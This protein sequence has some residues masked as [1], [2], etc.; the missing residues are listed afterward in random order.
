MTQEQ[1]DK[2]VQKLVKWGSDFEK[3]ARG[4]TNEIVKLNKE[5]RKLCDP[6]AVIPK[7]YNTI[8]EWLEGHPRPS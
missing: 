8:E 1:I 4:C 7:D 2:E 3:Q 5:A 6:H